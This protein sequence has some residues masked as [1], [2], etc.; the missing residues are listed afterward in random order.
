MGAVA[1]TAVYVGYKFYHKQTVALP[2]KG[3]AT[4]GD[5]STSMFGFGSDHPPKVG[6]EGIDYERKNVGTGIDRITNKHTGRHITMYCSRRRHQ[7][8]RYAVKDRNKCTKWKVGVGATRY[9]SRNKYDVIQTAYRMT[10]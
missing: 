4:G 5:K 8:N 9:E 10:L 7:D 2:G 1:I 6:E 3:Y